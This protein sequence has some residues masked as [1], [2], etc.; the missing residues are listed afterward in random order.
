MDRSVKI[1]L[2]RPI[3]VQIGPISESIY[4]R[5]PTPQALKRPVGWFIRL[6]IKCLAFFG[7]T[8]AKLAEANKLLRGQQLADGK[9][10]GKLYPGKFGLGRLKFGEFC[11][12]VRINNVVAVYRKVQVTLSI[13]KA[14][15]GRIFDRLSFAIELDDRSD[16]F[17][18]KPKFPDKPCAV[19]RRRGECLALTYIFRCR[20]LAVRRKAQ[21]KHC[22]EQNVKIGGF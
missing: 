18:R 16:L 20:L 21:T 3:R 13:S 8:P 9:F 6:L 10:V 1:R 22:A 5:V 12:N 11:V 4:W 7:K 15:S 19:I 2:I 17:R 14:F